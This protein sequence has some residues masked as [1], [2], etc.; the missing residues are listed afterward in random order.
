MI[1]SIWIRPGED[2]STA[3][4]IRKAVFQNEL[5]W[6]RDMDQDQVDPYALHLVLCLN[7]VPVATGRISYD[8][9]GKAK[10]SRICVLP[11]YRRQG[12]GDGLVKVL[13]YKS[14]QMK[15]KYSVVETTKELELF[16]M[17]IG[18][19]TVGTLNRY[20]MDLIIMEKE[21][22]DGTRENC[23]HQCTCS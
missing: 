20:G 21:T 7:D 4:E 17:R 15:M 8:G 10:L 1:T 2:L 14:S 5:H 13:D 9:V 18:Y 6:D 19:Q 12:I 3:L 23:A 11:K 16:Y 22:N